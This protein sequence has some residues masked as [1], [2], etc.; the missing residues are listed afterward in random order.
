MNYI[1]FMQE[2]SDLLKKLRPTGEGAS[3]N[4]WPGNEFGIFLI[5]KA[6]KQTTKK[7]KRSISQCVSAAGRKGKSQIHAVG[8]RT[9]TIMST[10]SE[11]NV[12]TRTLFGNSCP[13][14]VDM[15]DDVSDVSEW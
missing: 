6:L 8:Q 13:P 3:A 15:T 9:W 10:V 14:V 1:P 4:E 2:K 11:R 12:D 5:C 7:S